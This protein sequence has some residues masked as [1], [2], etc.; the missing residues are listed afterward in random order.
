MIDHTRVKLGKQP[1]RPDPR[2]LRLAD[3]LHKSDLPALK[4]DVDWSG[5]Q[6]D[7][8][9]MA[10]DNL[11]DCVEAAWGHFVQTESLNVP[12]G[13]ASGEKWTQLDDDTIIQLYCDAAG[14]VRGDPD[15]DNGSVIIDVLNF[16]RQNPTHGKHLLAFSSPDPQNLD[17][18]KYAIQLFGGIDIGVG[19]PLSAQGQSVWEVMGP[20]WKPDC[21]PYSWG[22]HSVYVNGFNDATQRFRFTSWGDEMEMSYPFWENYCDES[23]ALL[24][25]WWVRPEHATAG[26]DFHQLNLDLAK[27]TK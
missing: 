6:T 16:V 9:M 2:T 5:G 14:Y 26:F 3:Y 13:L 18:V 20:L 23:Y 12:G 19:L 10:N 25:G 11:G 8:G 27:V 7:W 1:A 15:T 21:R 22:G 24:G 17:H 4:S